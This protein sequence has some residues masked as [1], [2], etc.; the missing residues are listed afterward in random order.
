MDS[1]A[2]FANAV[3]YTCKML[4]TLATGVND[5]KRFSSSPTKEPIKLKRSSLPG[6]SSLA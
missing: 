4:M 5:R 1:I 2:Y 6:L 3:N